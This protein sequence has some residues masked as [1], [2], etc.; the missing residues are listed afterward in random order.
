MQLNFSGMIYPASNDH[1]QV[2][3]MS[4]ITESRLYVWTPGGEREI[5]LCVG[6]ITALP[7]EDKVDIVMVSAF[8]SKSTLNICSCVLEINIYLKNK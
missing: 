5:Q 2:K 4:L 8:P 1:S 3:E 6:D 7:V